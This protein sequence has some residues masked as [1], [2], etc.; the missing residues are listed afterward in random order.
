MANS[1]STDRLS[2]TRNVS[3]LVRAIRTP[4]QAN[5]NSIPVA[6]LGALQHQHVQHGVEQRRVQGVAVGR[7]TRWQS[8]LDVPVGAGG[9]GR[10]QPA[11]RGAVVVAGVGQPLI[12]RAE[13]E[14]FGPRGWPAPPASGDRTSD[15]SA[16]GP[17][18]PVACRVQSAPGSPAGRAWMAIVRWPRS[19]SSPTA[20]CSCVTPD[21]GSTSGASR[22]SWS[23]PSAPA[24]AAACDASSTN[25]VPGS[26]TRPPTA[27]SANQGVRVR[28]SRPLSSSPPDS[29]TSHRGVQHRVRRA[30]GVVEPE[31]AAVEGVGRQVDPACCGTRVERGPVHGHADDMGPAEETGERVGLGLTRPQRRHERHIARLVQALI[32]HRGQHRV[33]TQLQEPG[34]PLPGQRPDPVQEPHRPPDVLHPIPRIGQLTR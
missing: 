12:R 4:D 23:M 14:R 19:S 31:P 15:N 24:A 26:S 9:P 18:S 6:G 8:H 13:V 16:T 3:G 1:P 10:D 32:G 21:A 33:R 22:V 7:H 29:A 27:W 34:H 5:G 11:K 17:S 20:S 30:A 25:A 2:R 28:D